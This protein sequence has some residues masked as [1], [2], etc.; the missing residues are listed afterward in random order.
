MSKARYISLSFSAVWCLCVGTG[1]VRSTCGYGVLLG[2]K[3]AD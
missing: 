1:I 2:M 3:V